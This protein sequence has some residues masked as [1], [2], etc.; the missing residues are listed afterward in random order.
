M[1]L[2]LAQDPSRLNPP[3]R[4]PGDI[5]RWFAATEGGRSVLLT[6]PRI[7]GNKVWLDL[8]AIDAAGVVRP[9]VQDT[10]IYPESLAAGGNMV[11]WAS[12]N[13]NDCHLVQID[14]ATSQPVPCKGMA[15]S[16]SVAEG[17]LA[18]LN[19]RM[20]LQIYRLASGAPVLEWQTKVDKRPDRAWNISFSGPNRLLV[21]D[22]KALTVQSY[23]HGQDGS[24]TPS[25]PIRLKG[26]EAD[27][28][29]STPYLPYSFRAHMPSR[30][31][32]HDL[33]F[34]HPGNRI[35]EFDANGKQIGVHPIPGGLNFPSQV[36]DHIVLL[37]RNLVRHAMTR[38]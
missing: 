36:G 23:R 15:I 11:F 8:H 37:D 14:T 16:A 10:K 18:I 4:N 22:P 21:I 26:T 12:W 1:L 5:V 17:S 24:W 25:P 33:F 3:L 31:G 20:E 13:P 38:P 30:D 32:R 34:F 9:L 19:S 6:G 27:R 29:R 7:S 28:G 2:M 35:A